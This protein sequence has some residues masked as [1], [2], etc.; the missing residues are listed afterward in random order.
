MSLL[1]I[2]SDFSTSV[3]SIGSIPNPTRKITV[4]FSMDAVKQAI[5][6]LPDQSKKLVKKTYRLQESQDV[7]NYFMFEATEF[8]SF[9][10]YID[11]N[12]TDINETRTEIAVEVRRKIGS[13]DKTQEIQVAGTH[14]NNVLTGIGMLLDTSKATPKP[15]PAPVPEAP[16]PVQKVVQPKPEKKVV[17]KKVVQ[18]KPE[19]A[20]EAPKPEKKVVAK[21]VEK[22]KKIK[23]KKVR[24][25]KVKVKK[26]V[27]KKVVQP[28]PEKKIVNNTGG[29]ILQHNTFEELYSIAYAGLN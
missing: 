11:V 23:V 14:I 18:P 7:I 29:I 16:K 9:G 15:E 3:H 20:P 22:P 21:K 28:K 19:P 6:S 26:V 8:L 25:K 12:L 13:F 4:N 1:E 17:A 24:V 2:L 27:A 5:K 10:V